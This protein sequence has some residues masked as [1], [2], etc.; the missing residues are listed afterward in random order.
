MSGFNVL[1]YFFWLLLIIAFVMEAW[2]L[3]DSLSVP[4]GAYSAAGK[5]RKKM[6]MIV[7]IVATVV[8][9]A[10]AI[11]PGALGISPIGLLIGILPVAAFIAAAIYLADVR[12]AVA[13]YKKKNGRGDRSG[14]YGPW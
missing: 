1:D 3:I 12:P 13:P 14:P 2:A 8:G 5:W 9:G 4:E 11:A 10:H 6:W 7:L